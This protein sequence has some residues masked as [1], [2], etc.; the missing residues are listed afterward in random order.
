VKELALEEHVAVGQAIRAMRRGRMSLQE[1]A[2]RSNVSV[3]SLSQ[4]ENGRGNPSFALLGRIAAALNVEASQLLSAP[5]R[6]ATAI[7][8]KSARPHVRL[9]RNGG[10]VEL[11]TPDLLRDINVSR[12]ALAPGESVSFDGYSG[13]VCIL[14]ERGRM[15]IEHENSEAIDLGAGDAVSYTIPRHAHIQNVGKG[16]LELV[17]VFCPARPD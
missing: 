13:E 10:E 3:G 1:L 8:R 14:I 17:S 15:R 6:S 2:D 16:L 9:V 4:I 5:P 11:L 7:V 12:M